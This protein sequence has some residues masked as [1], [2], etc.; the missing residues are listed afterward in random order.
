M[1]YEST[2]WSLEV[3]DGWVH[4]SDDV[5]TTFQHPEGVGAFQVS[6]YHKDEVVTDDE[7]REYAGEIPLAAVSLGRLSGFRTRF[8][9]DDV[10]WIKW[11]L[12][13]GCQMIHVIYNCSLTDRGREDAEIDSMIE[14]L[15]SEHATNEA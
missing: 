10:F 4:E 5:C 15:T 2:D 12:R 6:S 8:S 7:L 13:S 3:P 11:W 14:S 1:R 9:Q